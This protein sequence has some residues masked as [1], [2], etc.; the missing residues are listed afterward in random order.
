MQNI[1]LWLLIGWSE[2]KEH[3]RVLVYNRLL[4]SKF[5]NKVVYIMFNTIITYTAFFLF[6][7]QEKFDVDL[8]DHQW[9]KIVERHCRER[10]K[11]HKCAFHKRYKELKLEGKDPL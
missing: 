9:L 5:C 1:I 6:Y 8:K 2:A 11:E 7:V 10:Y 4:V 3:D